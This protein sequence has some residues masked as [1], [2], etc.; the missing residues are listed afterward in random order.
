MK[1]ML[2][3]AIVMIAFTLSANA[4]NTNTPCSTYANETYKCVIDEGGSVER[5]N[6]EKL[7]AF[8]ACVLFE[9]DSKGNRK[10]PTTK[11]PNQ[12]SPS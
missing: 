9:Y 4:Q 11:Q 10:N 2:F 7:E 5:A 8:Y 1:K 6:A 12:L 3:S